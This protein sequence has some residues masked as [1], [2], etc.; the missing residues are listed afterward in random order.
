LSENRPFDQQKRSG[1]NHIDKAGARLIQARKLS[2]AKKV[3]LG[4]NPD[5]FIFNAVTKTPAREARELTLQLKA[6]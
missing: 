5:H 2:L 3:S 1:F 6:F 4:M